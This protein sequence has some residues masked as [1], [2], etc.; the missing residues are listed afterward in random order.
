MKDIMESALHR[1][2]SFGSKM[3]YFKPLT[4]NQIEQNNTAA[5]RIV[6]RLACGDS[7]DCLSNGTIHLTLMRNPA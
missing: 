3:G 1:L 4:D 2:V 5:R 7:E 6:E